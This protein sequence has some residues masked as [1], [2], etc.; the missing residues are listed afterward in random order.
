MTA[1]SKDYFPY[2]TLHG[3]EP[4]TKFVD[5]IEALD[6][7]L[8][9]WPFMGSE[10][11][12][13]RACARFA[14]V[15]LTAHPTEAQLDYQEQMILKGEV[16]GLW[17]EHPTFMFICRGLGLNL[18]L[19]LVRQRI[20]ITFSGQSSYCRDVRHEDALVPRALQRYPD[21][22][23]RY[24][25]WVKAGKQLYADMLDADP[26]P[27]C[28][29]DARMALPRGLPHAYGVSV[30]L[31][32]LLL[33]YSKRSCEQSEAPDMN[34]LVTLMRDK[35]VEKFPWTGAMFKKACDTGRCANLKPGIATAFMRDAQHSAQGQPDEMV[36][37]WA[38]RN[39]MMLEGFKQVFPDSK[40]EHDSG[41]VA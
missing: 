22:M 9:S 23:E 30:C 17:C 35:V 12:L 1:T 16:L 34:R 19:Q 6:V 18:A 40:H 25:E 15:N 2:S 32:T 14:C 8:T 13:L 28:T 21:L 4:K 27:V 10:D 38:T 20:G 41:H 24:L 29:I 31:S 37:Q 26:V 33:M 7:E 11:R 5:S 39:E 3:E 36:I